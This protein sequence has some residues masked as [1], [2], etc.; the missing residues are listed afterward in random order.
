MA[1]EVGKVACLVGGAL[2]ALGVVSARGAVL[3]GG[4]GGSWGTGGWSME[5]GR[6]GVVVFEMAIADSLVL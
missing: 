6:E 5:A 3:V 1:A 2:F 4:V